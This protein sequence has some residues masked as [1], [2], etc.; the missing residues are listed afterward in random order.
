[1][2]V[3]WSDSYLELDKIITLTLFRSARAGR[4]ATG[5]GWLI[6]LNVSIYAPAWGARDAEPG[7]G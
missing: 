6:H 3:G 7:D 2:A 4:L 5:M 1:M